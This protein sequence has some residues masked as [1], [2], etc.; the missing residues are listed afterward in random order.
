M[1]TII[2]TKAHLLVGEHF[3]ARSNST[4][5]TATSNSRSFLR[6]S[7]AA[8]VAGYALFGS[9]QNE[10]KA[11]PAAWFWSHAQYSGDHTNRETAEIRYESAPAGLKPQVSPV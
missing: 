4:F 10:A 5:L 2:G 11:N 7:I 6:T 9:N 8:S 3:P 1:A